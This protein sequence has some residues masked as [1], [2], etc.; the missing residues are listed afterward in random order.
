MGTRTATRRMIR[1]LGFES[2]GS[3][4]VPKCVSS[5]AGFNRHRPRADIRRLR[6]PVAKTEY[7]QRREGS[8]GLLESHLQKLLDAGSRWIIH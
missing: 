5:N 8:T 2:S 4:V 6:S 3:A 7:F 1:R